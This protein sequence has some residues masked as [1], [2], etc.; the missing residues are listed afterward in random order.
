MFCPPAV[1]RDWGA[2]FGA[3]GPPQNPF[4]ASLRAAA[5]FIQESIE[6][7][8][9]GLESCFRDT[10]PYNSYICGEAA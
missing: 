1:D 8:T 2:S 6:L 4:L 10:F 9:L 7:L 5:I 3:P